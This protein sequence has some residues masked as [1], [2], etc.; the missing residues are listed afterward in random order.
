MSLFTF[1]KLFVNY[2]RFAFEGQET[3]IDLTI[4]YT[5]KDYCFVLY[6]GKGSGYSL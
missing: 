4:K 2:Q 1:F 3:K 5:G 6:D